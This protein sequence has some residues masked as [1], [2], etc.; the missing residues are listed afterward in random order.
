MSDCMQELDVVMERQVFSKKTV[1]LGLVN[2]SVQT[3]SV[4]DEL[5]FAFWLSIL[6][7][8]LMMS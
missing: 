1:Q 3:E 5:A 2:D 8:P 4:I 7:Y 6:S